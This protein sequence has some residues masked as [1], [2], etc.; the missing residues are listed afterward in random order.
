[1]ILVFLTNN[2][3]NSY[4]AF[5]RNEVDGVQQDAGT[6]NIT[7]GFAAPYVA[8]GYTC[9]QTID[10][11]GVTI[12][13]IKVGVSTYS[14]T[15]DDTYTLTGFK[16]TSD[17]LFADDYMEY[18]SP[19]VYFS[20][21]PQGNISLTLNSKFNSYFPIPSFN[22]YNGWNV[23]GDK[24]KGIV[25]IDGKEQKSLFY[26]L[27]MNSVTLNRHG[28]NFTSKEEITS[29]LQNSDFF[30]QL[31]F[32][33]EQKENSLQY[34]LQKLNDSKVNNKYYYL[35]ILT[36]ES[37]ADISTLAIQPKPK[38]LIRN[39]FA[40]YPTNVSVKTEGS[41]VFPKKQNLNNK[42]FVV[43]ETGEFVIPN[44]MTIFFK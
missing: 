28:Q 29:Y 16:T 34:V 17:D 14:A 39:Y 36:D 43:K 7:T 12:E 1:M 24:Q 2:I 6:T 30:D 23:I 40:I 31:S 42:D 32:S 25:S 9:T 22:A 21:P 5:A 41:F 4:A 18:S 33:Q 44:S 27:A 13:C 38:K 26:E 35:T 37:I 8:L 20:N 15:Q 3:Q 10:W 11:N 19:F